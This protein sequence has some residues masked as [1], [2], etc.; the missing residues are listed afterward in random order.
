M[1]PAC[2]IS[3]LLFWISS[4]LRA[5]QMR[6][7][8]VQPNFSYAQ[9]R[10]LDADYLQQQ[11]EVRIDR[12][13]FEMAT[14]MINAIAWFTFSI[15]ILHVVWL[16]SFKASRMISIHVA[17]ALMAVGGA[18]TELLARLFFIGSSSTMEWMVKDFELDNWMENGETDRLGWKSLEVT[19]LAIMGVLTWVDALEY[20]FLAFIFFFLFISIW[21]K[22]ERVLSI[23]W[24]SFGLFLSLLSIVD[25]AADIM[26]YQNWRRYSHIAF[27]ISSVNR[28]VLF[29]VWLIWLSFQIPKAELLLEEASKPT[30]ETQ[31]FTNL[32]DESNDH[33][34]S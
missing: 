25:F 30:A 9:W 11:W 31:K 2:I 10:D 27:F 22:S 18:V 15:P 3:A 21:V 19:H 4:C 14:G 23:G 28:L 17:I 29:P 34:V 16:Q 24:A 33:V 8:K 32:P 20:L 7:W 26:R 1:D 13:S 12:R 5:A 6:Q